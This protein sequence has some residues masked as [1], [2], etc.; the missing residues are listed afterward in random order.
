M[1]WLILVTILFLAGPVEATARFMT[2][3]GST[4]GTCTTAGT[5]CR[6]DYLRTVITCGDT[7]TLLDGTYQ[8]ANNML[9]LNALPPTNKV[10]TLGNEV[11][12]SAE[13]DG[14]VFIDGQ[15]ARIPFWA[16]N[17]QYWIF[18]GFDIGNSN[19]GVVSLNDSSHITLQ[20]ICG[21]NN[22]NTNP[23]T[24]VHVLALGDS[25]NNT[26]EDVC[27]FGV[28]RNT[29]IEAGSSA[30]NVYRRI[31]ARHEGF[32]SQPGIG[33]TPVAQVG[34]DVPSQ[35]SLFENVIT[36][37]DTRQ[38]M[39][40]DTTCEG[41][42][43][44]SLVIR[45]TTPGG[46]PGYTFKGW[47]AY[48]KDNSRIPLNAAYFHVGNGNPVAVVD[49]FV[50]ITAAP[51]D[52]SVYGVEID[53][54]GASLDRGTVIRAAGYGLSNTTGASVTNFNEC[55]SLGACPNFYTGDTPGT[56]ARNCFRY[57]NGTLTS[58][59]LWPWPMD[60]RI[61]AA[62]ARA[63]AAGTGGGALSGTAGAGYAAGTVTSEIV[64]RYGAVPGACLSSSSFTPNFPV[65]SDFPS[66]SVRD[67][68]DRANGGLGAGWTEI[69]SD[70]FAIVS[71]QVVAPSAGG[72]IARAMYSDTR[73]QPDHEVYA[74]WPTVPTA[75]ATALTFAGTDLT[76]CN[77][78]RV[79]INPTGATTQV[80]VRRIDGACASTTIMAAVDLGTA[81]VDGNSFGVRVSGTTI[82][83][84]WKWTDGIWYRIGQFT[85]ANLPMSA[86]GVYGGIAGGSPAVIDNYGAGPFVDQPVQE[87]PSPPASVGAG[88]FGTTFPGVR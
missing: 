4:A 40:T 78:Y 28:G 17:M 31:W 54:A 57:S 71:N 3:N 10:C 18:S 58:T 7:V 86:T 69:E 46:S 33:G 26:F 20:R 34:Y 79:V 53:E 24:N 6:W 41:A 5:A 1:I 48:G 64:S 52:A 76:A 19:N 11:T 63:N 23:G 50:D 38:Q 59:P 13:T 77:Q 66:V 2:N 82:S 25:S 37:L 47:I 87:P 81:I 32:F 49:V 62:L 70:I 12:M 45:D 84:Y 14:G 44:S 39:T 61:K 65:A 42:C 21:S 56:G 43:H 55:A 67:D 22:I 88:R 16:I 15:F 35:S 51:V 83:V 73:M 27:L 8:G 85:D 72:N 60:D 9:D 36:V 74:T 80:D 75:F 30:N 29:I 68:F